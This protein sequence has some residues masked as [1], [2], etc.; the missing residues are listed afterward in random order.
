MDA[1]RVPCC[2]AEREMLVQAGLGEKK[3]IIPDIACSVGEFKAILVKA[4]R[5]LWWV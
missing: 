4:A 5:K 3:V 2:V 1:I